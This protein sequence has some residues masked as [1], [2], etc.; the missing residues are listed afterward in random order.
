MIKKT[1]NSSYTIL[2]KLVKFLEQI[3]TNVVIYLL[4]Y[5]L[6]G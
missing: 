5:A 6:I 3:K 2:L 4:T 1:K